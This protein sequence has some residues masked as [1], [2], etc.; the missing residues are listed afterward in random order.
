[1]P[2]S[3]EA[4]RLPM[5]FPRTID[6]EHRRRH[7]AVP[8]RRYPSPLRP[9]VLRRKHLPPL[10]G[11]LDGFV[12]LSLDGAPLL[13]PGQGGARGDR[14]E[15]LPWRPTDDIVHERRAGD[16]RPGPPRGDPRP[17][18]VATGVL[19][20]PVPDQCAAQRARRLR[21]CLVFR[22][23][24]GDRARCQG[25]R[26]RQ[27]KSLAQTR[28]AVEGKKRRRTPPHR[29]WP[30]SRSA[31]HRCS[32]SGAPTRATSAHLPRR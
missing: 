2:G 10:P 7:R 25:S 15:G 32:R 27:A 5:G 30:L 24:V 18:R 8:L 29:P 16:P 22:A 28:R 3:P 6:R 31:W 21:A 20:G 13:R 23:E 14:N 12:V 19:H 11:G 1:M 9:A 4:D 26:R 17:A